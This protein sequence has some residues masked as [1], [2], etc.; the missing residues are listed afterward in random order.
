[1]SIIKKKSKYVGVINTN[2]NI[3]I[4][5]CILLKL[6]DVYNSKHFVFII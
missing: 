6:T 5:K 1:M 2:G 3:I 4:I